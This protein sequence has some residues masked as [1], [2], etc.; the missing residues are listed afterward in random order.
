MKKQLACVTRSGNLLEV[1]VF[2]D[3]LTSKS[4][5]LNGQGPSSDIVFSSRIRLARNISDYPFP[6]RATPRQR[7]TVLE[8][9]S[10]VIPTVGRLEASAFVEIQKLKPLDRLFLMER[11][12]V[13]QEHIAFYESSELQGRGLIVSPDERIAVM[14]N[15]E[16]HIRA[17]FITSGFDLNFCWQMMNVIDDELSQK[18]SYAFSPDFGYLAACTTNVGTGLRASCMLHLPALVLTKNINKI[19]ELLAKISFTTRGLFGEGTQALGNFFQISNQ[20]SLGVSEEELI[21]NLAGVVNQVKEQE[22]D[23]RDRLLKNKYKLNIEDGIWRALGIL[24]NCRLITT[25]EALSHLSMLSLGLDLGIIKD[26]KKELLNNLIIVIQPA[27]LQKI[28]NKTLKETERDYIR[29]G[30]LREWLKSKPR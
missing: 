1:G 28:E 8:K 20:I 9:L 7:N 29:A 6:S 16:D 17:Q 15:E 21:D 12:L 23:A 19:L 5:W 22:I 3:F 30:I 26:I 11:H 25:K 24:K 4:S 14:I 2:E 18:L 10:K 27:H 13:S